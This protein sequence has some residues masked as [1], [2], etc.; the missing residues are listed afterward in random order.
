MSKIIKIQHES[1][2]LEL[3]Y[4]V[5][6]LCCDM[7]TKELIPICQEAAISIST[8]Y[9]WCHYDVISPHLRTVCR[10]LGAL[11]YE[12]QTTTVDISPKLK[13]AA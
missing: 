1:D 9:R 2:G 6:N 11:G 10:M 12:I 3:F 5:Q 4:F 13:L 8:V 7:S